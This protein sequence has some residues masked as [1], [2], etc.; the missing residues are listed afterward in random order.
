M[1]KGAPDL[2]AC[3]AQ[4]AAA[5]RQLAAA[6]SHWCTRSHRS[7]SCTTVSTYP[8]GRRWPSILIPAWAPTASPPGR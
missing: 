7:C 6:P 4:I 1:T 5:E 8:P 2:A 3:D